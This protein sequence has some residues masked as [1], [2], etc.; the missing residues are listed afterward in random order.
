[1]AK[2]LVVDDDRDLL[3]PLAELLCTA[4]HRVTTATSAEEALKL[5]DQ[6]QFDLVISDIGLPDLTGFELC[7]KSRARQGQGNLPFIFMS[8]DC[9]ADLERDRTQAARL[10]AL[11]LRKPLDPAD[12]LLALEKLFGSRLNPASPTI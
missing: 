5:I 10:G 2:L 6:Q 1:M 4:G 8:G 9:G 12:L 3:Y 7:R 11:F